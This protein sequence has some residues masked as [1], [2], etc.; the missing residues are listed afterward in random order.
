MHPLVIPFFI[1]HAGCPHT[2]IFCDQKLVSGGT[3][4]LPAPDRIRQ[5][6]K[7]WLLRSPGRPAEAAFFGGSFSLLPAAVQR[8]LLGAVKAFIDDGSIS[9][10]RI[11]TRP[12]ALGH[13]TLSLLRDQGVRTIEIGV[14]SMDE[15]VLLRCERG[16]TACDAA[17]AIAR[18]AEAGFSVGAQLLPGLPGDSQH[19]AVQSVH[20]VITAGAQFIRIY[21]AVVLAGTRLAE[22]YA[23]GEYSPPDLEQGVQTCARMLQ[24]SLR[25][26][27]P[28]IRIGLQAEASLQ[29]KDTILAG[30]W[31]PALG[32][33]VRSQLYFDLI[34]SLISEAALGISIS[35]VC[36]PHN[37]SE[38]V[39]NRKQNLQRLS[40]RG[41]K[42]VNITADASL[43]PGSVEVRYLNQNLKGNILT[44][45]N[46]EGENNA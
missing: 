1:P 39:G 15:Q 20:D 30:C 32:Q 27:I 11:S 35:L 3:A 37:I 5:T 40:Q 9:G 25:N 26:A 44:S 19:R 10:I 16:H 46:Y 36:H 21:P 6:V 41:V 22:L 14:Q 31:H 38:V 45:L 42:V 43:T 18:V 23:T 33:L 13:D 4:A 17:E 2:C 29:Q 12:D 8:N 24:I 7:E 34:C 28:V